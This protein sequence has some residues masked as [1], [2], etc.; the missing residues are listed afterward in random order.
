VGLIVLIVLVI[1]GPK[2]LTSIA[3]A[4]GG[5]V[6]ELRRRAGR[7]DADAALPAPPPG[8]DASDPGP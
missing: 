5:G 2:R 6:R 3:R 7:D 1:A 4:A 8:A